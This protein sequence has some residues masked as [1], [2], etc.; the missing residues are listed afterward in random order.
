MAPAHSVYHTHCY[1]CLMCSLSSRLIIIQFPLQ[2]RKP[3]THISLA[4]GGDTRHRYHA[5]VPSFSSVSYHFSFPKVRF[6]IESK[7]SNPHFFSYFPN[8]FPYNLSF[9]SVRVSELLNR[10]NRSHNFHV[11]LDLSFSLSQKFVSILIF[12][13][14]I[15]YLSDPISLYLVAK[16]VTK[17]LR[18]M[19]Y[20]K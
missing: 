3:L 10:T 4:R 14:V 6:S 16:K 15:V 8:I 13:F 18:F 5:P 19:R 11:R 9:K 7:L 12:K 2:P 17:I 1:G 20:R